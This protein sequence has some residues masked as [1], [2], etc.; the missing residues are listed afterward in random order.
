M[1]H[2]VDDEVQPE[3]QSSPHPEPQSF[4]DWFEKRI[5]AVFLSVLAT[6]VVI[7]VF[8]VIRQNSR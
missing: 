7:V 8:R 6:W 4:P 2:L 1:S 3:L 5:P